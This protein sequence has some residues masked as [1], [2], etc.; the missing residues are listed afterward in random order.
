MSDSERL[1]VGTPVVWWMPPDDSEPQGR[2]FHGV[3]EQAHPNGTYHITW[4]GG[5][6]DR[7]PRNQIEVKRMTHGVNPARQKLRD[8][9]RE[10]EHVSLSATDWGSQLPQDASISVVRGE[11][12]GKAIVAVQEALRVA[13]EL[14]AESRAPVST[15]DRYAS[16][17][18]RTTKDAQAAAADRIEAAIFLALA[19]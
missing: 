9:A 5:G 19:Y 13:E 12:G 7:V 8:Y 1:A 3:I 2:E 18:E 10:Q 14:R 4:N 17:Q 15:S 11:I 16:L 6:A